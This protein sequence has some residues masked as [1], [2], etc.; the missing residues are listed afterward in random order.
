MRQQGLICPH[1]QAGIY[2]CHRVAVLLTVGSLCQSSVDVR[3]GQQVGIALQG[4]YP[5][6]RVADHIKMLILGGG[7][8]SGGIQ[9]AGEVITRIHHDRAAFV[10]SDQT[11][12]HTGEVYAFFACDG[13]STHFTAGGGQFHGFAITGERISLDIHA[14]LICAAL[15]LQPHA[16]SA[17]LRI[18]QAGIRAGGGQVEADRRIC[19]GLQILEGDATARLPYRYGG[20]DG[21]ADRHI[22]QAG[23]RDPFQG[24]GA[25]GA[26]LHLD[27][28]VRDRQIRDIRILPA[29][30]L[31]TGGGGDGDPGTV[32]RL[33]V[34]GL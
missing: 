20:A 30:D 3:I 12:R 27:G 6:Y 25:G 18:Q 26:A 7:Q 13:I 34:Q 28:Q 2:V 19:P 22:F 33:A 23:V 11:I 8:G 24:Q 15:I 21:T 14:H 4:Q 5:A 10:L 16:G 31:H 17:D 9:E 32:Y 29:H 1:I